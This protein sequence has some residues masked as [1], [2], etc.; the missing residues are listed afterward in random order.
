MNK[1]Q[2]IIWT[3]D[4]ISLAW[5]WYQ[6]S[7]LIYGL[8]PRNNTSCCWVIFFIE[9]EHMLLWNITWCNL[10]QK[11]SLTEPLFLIYNMPIQCYA[12]L[13]WLWQ[14]NHWNHKTCMQLT[15]HRDTPVWVIFLL[16]TAEHR[17]VYAIFIAGKIWATFWSL[18]WISVGIMA[19]ETYHI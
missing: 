18:C 3:N 4:G 17:Q 16:C 13:G 1:P 8:I 19:I 14:W 9:T 6:K 5:S 7:K 10:L 2:A 15:T 11:S 12:S